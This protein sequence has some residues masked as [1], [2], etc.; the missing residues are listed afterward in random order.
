MRRRRPAYWWTELIRSL[1]EICL[2]A[3]RRMQRSKTGIER[4]ERRVELR[5]AKATLKH[6][7]K[8]SKKTCFKELCRDADVNGQKLTAIAELAV[9]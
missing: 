2:R 3:R 8:L 5:T 7:I 6:E 1:R 9:A 4:Q